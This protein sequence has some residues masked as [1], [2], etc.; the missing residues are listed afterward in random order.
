MRPLAVSD[1]RTRRASSFARLAL[2]QALAPQALQQAAEVAEVEVEVGA[3]LAR[4]ARA[5]LADL[6]EH[7]RLRQRE[8]AAEVARLQRA[9]AAGVEAVEAAHRIDVAC[10][11]HLANYLLLSL[12][13]P[14]MNLFDLKG[15]TALVTGGN[16]GIGLGMAQGPGAGRRASGDRRPRRGE[17]RRAR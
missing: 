10:R 8:R 13:N 17:E 15:K 6:V 12:H 3:E 4:G 11:I 5:A 1:S 7:A 16:G 9:D 14:A 2:H